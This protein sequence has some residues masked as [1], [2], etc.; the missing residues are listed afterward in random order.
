[1]KIWCD[2]MCR[3]V[4]VKDGRA[5][6]QMRREKDYMGSCKALNVVGQY[7]A[8]NVMFT[9]LTRE[10]ASDRKQPLDCSLKMQ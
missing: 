10:R 4:I 2:M 9:T 7:E 3:D 6:Y 1:M 5:R 8:E